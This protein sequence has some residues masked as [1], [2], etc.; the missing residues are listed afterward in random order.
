VDS[1]GDIYVADGNNNRVLEYTYPVAATGAGAAHVF[2]QSG[3]FTSKQQPSS[4]NASSLSHPEGV[5]VDP[6]DNLYIA[7]L[8]NSRVLEFNTPLKHTAVPGSGDAVGDM[9]FG[10]GGDFTSAAG[11][12]GTLVPNAASLGG[13]GAVAVDSLGNLYIVDTG[14]N[15]VSE[16]NQPAPLLPAPTPSA[17]H[18]PGPSPTHTPT[19][20]RTH[21]PL[22]TRTS[23]STKTPPPTATRT[24]VA[25][26]SAT[27][28]PARTPTPAPT[29]TPISTHT[30][31]RTPTHTPSSTPTPA[32]P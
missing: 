24:A 13:P 23:T 7:D 5:A 16:Y 31:T 12:F 32:K 25:S 29:H 30:A 2:G 11:N 9:V 10:Q 3:S 18:T 21:T 1:A 4:V 6:A 17:T 19:P 14:N 8:N 28:T 22:P 26:E 15:R 20:T 27:R